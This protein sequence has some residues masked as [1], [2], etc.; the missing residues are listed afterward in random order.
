LRPDGFT[1]RNVAARIAEKGDLF[2]EVLHH[3]QTLPALT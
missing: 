2:A 1:I 3:G